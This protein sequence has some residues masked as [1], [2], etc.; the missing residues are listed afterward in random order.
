[1]RKSYTSKN[2]TR[3]KIEV[4]ELITA[5]QTVER[6]IKSTRGEN[7]TGKAEKSKQKLL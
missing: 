6:L 5:I 3:E 2:Y 4:S 7:E 1:M